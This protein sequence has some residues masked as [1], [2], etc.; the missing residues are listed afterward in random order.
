LYYLLLNNG[1]INSNDSD[2]LTLRGNMPMTITQNS[3][4]RV[5]RT[6]LNKIAEQAGEEHDTIKMRLKDFSWCNF[7]DRIKIV[8]HGA[9]PKKIYAKPLKKSNFAGVF[10]RVK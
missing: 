5:V 2:V 3:A 9:K 1:K 4:P 7:Q 6:L 8:P 10:R